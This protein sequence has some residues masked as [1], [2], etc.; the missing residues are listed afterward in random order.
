MQELRAG[1]CR[2]VSWIICA[3]E[4]SWLPALGFRFEGERKS[5]EHHE[6]E[7]GQ[8]HPLSLDLEHRPFVKLAT[9]RRGAEKITGRVEQQ[10]RVGKIAVGAVV[11]EI[12]QNGFAP[13]STGSRSQLERRA[14]ATGAAAYRYSVHIACG[15][16]D[17]C[18]RRANSIHSRLVEVMQNL[19]LP[20]A[21]GNRH[22]LEDNAAVDVAVAAAAAGS[23]V[24]IARRIERERCG[25]IVAVSG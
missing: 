10:R 25:R 19:L 14:V 4:S 2:G 6:P 23:A 18:A 1:R 3:K 12:M 22:Q 24:E 20:L 8:R 13:T 17:Q 16:E 21:A 5:D 7:A 11:A 15:V 9:A